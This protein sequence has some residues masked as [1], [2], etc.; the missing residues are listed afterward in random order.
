[1]RGRMVAARLFSTPRCIQA[2]APSRTQV[3]SIRNQRLS[4]GLLRCG[5]QSASLYKLR[6]LQAARPLSA[7]P[8]A[9]DRCPSRKELAVPLSIGSM[10][11]L[12]P[13]TLWWFEKCV[14]LGP[15]KMGLP[16]LAVIGV[17]LAPADVMQRIL[18]ERDVGQLPLLPY[19][20]MACNG[21]IWS[22]Y[23]LL[24]AL[25]EVWA[26][27]MIGIL[28]G[29]IYSAI[30]IK[31]CPPGANWLPGTTSHHMGG[32]AAIMATIV[33]IAMAPIPTEIKLTLVG[34]A[35]NLSAAIMFAGPLTAVKSIIAE[36][37][38]KSLPF[39][40]T[41]LC[42]VNCT[43]WSIYGYSKEDYMIL[44]PNAAGLLLSIF[45]LSLFARFGIHR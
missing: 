11:A 18:K 17:F 33:G 29:G 44:A 13:A 35:G 43:L 2:V 1:M 21:V 4:Q 34:G 28:C 24:K 37:N 41:I 9:D 31:H 6:G 25:P 40:F 7:A 8:A 20:A 30:Y 22:T 36:K 38:T 16:G 10:F 23:G 27:N 26:P 3:S 12:S 32:S 14:A 45:Q 19:S 15:V 42:F 5:R 39:A